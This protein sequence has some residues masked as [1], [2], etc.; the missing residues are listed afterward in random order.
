M[1]KP[2]TNNSPGHFRYI[3]KNILGSPER[4]SISNRVFLGVVLTTSILCL[5]TTV[6][7]A[8]TSLPEDIV[9]ASGLSAAFFV[10]VYYLAYSLGIFRPFVWLSSV[11]LIIF[12][13]YTWIRNGGSTGATHC[14]LII[15]P[16]FYLPFAS[17]VQR[18]VLTILYCMTSAGL[19]TFEYLRPDIIYHYTGTA[20]RYFDM[21]FATLAT[22]MGTTFAI[23]FLIREFYQLASRLDLLREKSERRFGDIADTIPAIICELNP[24]LSIE[25]MNKAGLELTGYGDEELRRKD[26][27]KQLIH[28]EDWPAVKQN[29]DVTFSGKTVPAG[30]CRL[31]LKNGTIKSV[32]VRAAARTRD[33]TISG[34]RLYMVDITEKKQIELQ[35]LK[36]QKMESVG[37]LAGGI[38]HDFNNLL[39]GIMGYAQLIKM[40]NAKRP[41]G[42]AASELDDFIEPI[43]NASTRAAEL[44]RRLLIFTRQ[45]PLQKTDFDIREVLT[46]IEKLLSRTID[47]KI[48]IRMEIASNPLLLHGDRTLLQSAIMNLCVNA[49]DAMPAG[50]TLTL[51]CSRAVSLHSGAWAPP[52]GQTGYMA[53]RIADTGVGMTDE[54]KHHLFEPFFTT[55]SVGKG[56][57]LGLASVYGTIKD[58]NGHIEVD[59]EPGRGTAFTLY[60]PIAAAELSVQHADEL[61]AHQTSER[62]KILVVDDEE[63]IGS[64]VKGILITEGHTVTVFSNPKEAL[65]SVSGRIMPYTLAI[66]DMIMPGM[67]GLE[68]ITALRRI[69]PRLPAILMSG[70]VSPEDTHSFPRDFTIITLTKP[71]DGQILFKTIGIA[72]NAVK[73]SKQ[74]GAFL[75][76]KRPSF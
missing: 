58:H 22:Q 25:Y 65:A 2:A 64:L 6:I 39:T 23:S 11:W 12:V 28:P 71:F 75:A 17:H 34:I 21:M 61:P 46:E 37:M 54:V 66:V 76:S 1:N 69:N 30:E 73:D 67:N 3:L 10:L 33:N 19:L 24:D 51:A 27:L 56:T 62:L 60:L 70:Y 20:E 52:A 49:R 7:N 72:I 55:K 42:E 68:L 63:M 26:A 44:I 35:Y 29:A 8:L 15:L 47:K 40:S 4:F 59:S 9:I 14:F 53:I 31:V 48:C 38:A 45:Q 18:I 32:L 16:L 74:G 50:G 43:I 57:G 13:A 36:A 5:C 41:A